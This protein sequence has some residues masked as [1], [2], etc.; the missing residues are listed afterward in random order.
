MK[1]V[2]A[3]CKAVL[4]EGAG[5]GE[6]THGVCAACRAGLITVFLDTLDGPTFLVGGDARARNANAAARAAVAKEPDGVE[7]RLLGEVFDCLDASGPGG[8]GKAPRCAGCSLIL[9]VEDT[10]K[11]GTP[12]ENFPAV[13]RKEGGETL[14]F[15]V[16]TRRVKE[17]VL[18]RVDPAAPL[19]D[20]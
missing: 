9:K 12:H 13:L 10:F 11:T 18:L 6:A 3:W 7:G 19:T 17:G 16:S 2:C 4:G 15:A 14:R 20:V 1:R 8:C 5:T